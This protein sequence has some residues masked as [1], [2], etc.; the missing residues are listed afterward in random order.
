MQEAAAACRRCGRGLCQACA[1]LARGQLWCQ[2]C[3]LAD[4][5]DRITRRLSLG[6]GL[7]VLAVLNLPIPT[8]LAFCGLACLGSAA[9]R[10]FAVTK[11]K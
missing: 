1:T 6:G 9:R 4:E 7:L 5:D 3:A 10:F 11:R 8:I 2:A